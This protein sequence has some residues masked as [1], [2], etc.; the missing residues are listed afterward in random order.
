MTTYNIIDL[1]W[2]FNF[3]C[4]EKDGKPLRSDHHHDIEWED[5]HSCFLLIRDTFQADSG[6]YK[7][8]ATNSAGTASCQATLIVQPLQ[9]RKRKK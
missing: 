7:V 8:S 1:K 3:A 9:Y 5:K 6:Q 4:R 2:F